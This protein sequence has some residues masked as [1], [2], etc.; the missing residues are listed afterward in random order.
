[1]DKKTE[2]VEVELEL[3]PDDNVLCIR[4]E[5]VILRFPR[6]AAGDRVPDDVLILIGIAE[7]FKNASF[8]NAML[9]AAKNTQDA[10]HLGEF[11]INPPLQ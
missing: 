1:M 11:L 4:G 7:L 8:R 9:K 5:D 2:I 6:H 3:E 10:G